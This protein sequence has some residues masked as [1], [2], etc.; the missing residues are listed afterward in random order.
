M[1]VGF[2]L[3]TTQQF[4]ADSTGGTGGSV[5]VVNATPTARS[6]AYCCKTTMGAGTV[7]A[8]WTTYAGR[9][10]VTHATATELWYAFGA[11]FHLAAAT[12]APGPA[13]FVTYDPGGNYNLLLA[14]DS[15]TIRG[16]YC[17]ANAPTT[18]G[19]NAILIA[20]ASSSLTLD[21]WHHIDVRVVAS[22]TTTGT[23]EVWV[24]G[25]RVINATGVRT[26]QTTASMGSFSLG[27]TNAPTSQGTGHTADYHAFDDLRVN[28]TTGSVNAGR[29]GDESILLM[30]PTGAGD[31]TQLSRG[32]TD[33]GANW[34]QVDEVP[35][36][37]GTDYVTGAT[38]G[39][40]DLYN[41]TDVT[42]STVSA[43]S[44]WAQI[45]NPGVGGGS[46][47]LPTKSPAGQSDGSAFALTAAWTIV[48]RLLETDPAD[49]LA[50]SQAKITALQAGCKIAS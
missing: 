7:G 21:A 29:C 13:F 19:T 24:D 22:T 28:D 15:G 12:T 16:Y 2:E 3:G 8:G 23:L 31:L 32:G 46:V 30:V 44:V 1:Q 9:K 6:G 38:V 18:V 10:H 27:M 5:A 26:A 17:T 47:Y 42:V 33:S 34:S 39:F 43:L 49:G 14:I 4:G 25:A 20:A 48:G 37:S 50:W 36:G 11:F 41:L 35:P 45:A 40:T